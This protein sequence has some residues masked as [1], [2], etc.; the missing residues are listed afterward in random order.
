[1]LY[2][3]LVLVGA[4][5]LD[6]FEGVT[7]K[8][9]GAVKGAVEGVADAVAGKAL[10]GASALAEALSALGLTK[11]PLT[12]SFSSFSILGFMLSASTRHLL[13]GLL[14]DFASALAA[15]VVAGVGAFAATTVMV[16]P[17][18]RIFD[19]KK[20]Q[21]GG[22]ALI[23]KTCRITI[24]ADHSGGQAQFDEGNIIVTVRV[25]AGK[26]AVGEEAIIL[27]RQEDGVFVVEALK[28]HLPSQQDAFAELQ[29][30]Q[31]T[32]QETQDAAATSSK[33]HT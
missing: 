24:D 32:R 21:Q 6:A 29:T 8:A 4:A 14:P 31:E 2:W 7:G 5:D 10:G 12:I 25:I 9:E 16:R 11:V 23:G 1:L 33:K 27:D 30:Q 26:L 18:A 28:A 3:V 19:D 17:L 15:L 20:A 22:D 13:D